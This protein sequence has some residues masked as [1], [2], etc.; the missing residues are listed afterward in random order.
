[1]TVRVAQGGRL[2]TDARGV[3]RCCQL[4]ALKVSKPLSANAR[5]IA[6]GVAMALGSPLWFFVYET[7]VLTALLVWSIRVHREADEA[8]T[9]V[10]LNS[11]RTTGR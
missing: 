4:E 2:E 5:T 11:P 1:M 3:F 7:V 8:T 10:L 9:Y 6:L